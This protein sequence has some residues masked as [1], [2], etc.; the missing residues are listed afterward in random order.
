MGG[1]PFL[2]IK[3]EPPVEM[4]CFASHESCYVRHCRVRRKALRLYGI[5]GIKK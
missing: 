1:G 2:F 4:Q 5:C 3:N